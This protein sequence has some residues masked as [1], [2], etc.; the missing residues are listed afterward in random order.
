MIVMGYVTETSIA[1]LFVGGIVP[2]FSW[3]GR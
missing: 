1:A 2:G 3:R